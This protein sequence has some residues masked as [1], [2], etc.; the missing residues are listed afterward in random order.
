[1]KSASR[2]LIYATA[3]SYFAASLASLI[4]Y[5]ALQGIPP[6]QQA[7]F[8][9]AL[10]TVLCFICLNPIK[11][12]RYFMAAFYGATAAIS[13][14][15]I[16]RWIN[17]N[18]SSDI[19][20]PAMAA[21]DLALAVALIQYEPPTK[22]HWPRLRKLNTALVIILLAISCLEL[23]YPLQLPRKAPSEARHL[24]LDYGVNVSEGLKAKNQVGVIHGDTIYFTS[25]IDNLLVTLDNG[26]VILSHLENITISRLSIIG[27]KLRI[28]DC[29]N[30][31]ITRTLIDAKGAPY[32]IGVFNSY[33]ITI[34]KY[35]L[36]NCGVGVNIRN[37]TR[38]FVSTP[39][40][41]GDKV[42]G[43][44]TI[45]KWITS[46]E[47]LQLWKKW[48]RKNAT[49]S[50]PPL[51]YNCLTKIKEGK[52]YFS[53]SINDLHIKMD[54][55]TIILSNMEKVIVYGSIFQGAKL[56]ID[57]CKHVLVAYTY[58][59][60]NGAPYALGVFNSSDVIIQKYTIMNADI[61]IKLVN[62]TRVSIESLNASGTSIE[63]CTTLVFIDPSSCSNYI[64]F[65]GGDDP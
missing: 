12:V 52:L 7:I 16:Q 55:G 48:R 38:I 26:T 46:K 19:L 25:S 8:Y 47:A 53:S 58:I 33:N 24:D 9:F 56:K 36:A 50:K 60:A 59:D 42:V 37:S 31:N 23:V 40:P 18:G 21:W 22:D 15:G 4:G 63:N 49:I 32:A 6:T 34:Q 43:D 44:Q 11:H 1:M 54:N 5:P 28:E 29:R 61:G 65:G 30:I 64:F 20:G 2:A 57:R 45:P 39:V 41:L 27:G 10:G 13:F 51:G 3:F 35:V 62:S 14:A 17:Y